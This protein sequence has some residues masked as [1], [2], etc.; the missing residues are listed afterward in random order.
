MSPILITLTSRSNTN[1]ERPY[2]SLKE[3]K[4]GGVDLNSN[5]L[6]NCVRKNKGKILR[7]S[8]ECITPITKLLRKITYSARGSR[9]ASKMFAEPDFLFSQN[10]G[11]K[12]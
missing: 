10:L 9:T 3:N 2:V 1:F 11:L 5:R 7:L 8:A 6:D 4:R 12:F